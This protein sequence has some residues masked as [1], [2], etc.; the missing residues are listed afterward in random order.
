MFGR[1]LL[2]VGLHPLF[3]KLLTNLR[4]REEVREERRESRKGKVKEKIGNGYIS[5]G[6]GWRGG[7]REE[8]VNIRT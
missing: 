1:Q 5:Y 6:K 7:E 2:L 3:L 4:E 8:K